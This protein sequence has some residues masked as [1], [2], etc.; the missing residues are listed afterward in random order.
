MWFINTSDV[1]GYGTFTFDEFSVGTTLLFY[2]LSIL[3]LLLLDVLPAGGYICLLIGVFW[4][5]LVK[6]EDKQEIKRLMKREESKDFRKKRRKQRGGGG[7]GG[8]FLIFIAFLIVV[9]VDGNWLVPFGD[10]SFS[11]FVFAYI[12][13]LVWCA[14]I[15]GIP[16][17]IIFVLWLLHKF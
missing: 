3:W 5:K 9:F 16:A 7:G 10:L 11:Y 8:S 13:G 12:S 1:G 2:L 15:A 4:W 14:I 17:C 6:E